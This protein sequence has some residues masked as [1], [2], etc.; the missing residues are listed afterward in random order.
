MNIQHRGESG[1]DS[2]GSGTYTWNAATGDFSVTVNVD[3]NLEW[4]SPSVR[5]CHASADR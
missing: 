2:I 4:S 3:T 1:Q 5:P